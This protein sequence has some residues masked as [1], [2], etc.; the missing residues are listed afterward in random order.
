MIDVED[1]TS[2]LVHDLDCLLLGSEFFNGD[3]A[4]DEGD[5]ISNR[6]RLQEAV[7]GQRDLVEYIILL[8]H[9]VGDGFIFLEGG[10]N[11]VFPGVKCLGVH[12]K[13]RRRVQG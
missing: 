7:D 5:E 9:G 12:S 8:P 3:F 10:G 2:N 4:S 11:V 13:G 1:A 6:V